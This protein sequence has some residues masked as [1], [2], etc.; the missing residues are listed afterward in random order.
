MGGLGQWEARPWY[1]E[2]DCEVVHLSLQGVSSVYVVSVREEG[3]GG[4]KGRG[5]SLTEGEGEEVGS[6]ERKEHNTYKILTG[7][8]DQKACSYK[9]FL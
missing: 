5:G 6:E 3:G 2:E 4:G 8:S 7:E 9:A 1:G